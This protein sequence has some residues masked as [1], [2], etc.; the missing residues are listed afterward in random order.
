MDTVVLVIHLIFAIALIALVLIQR[1]E[2]GGLGIG[3]GSGGLGAFASAQST[4]NILTRLTAIFAALF[5]LT[6]IIL[7]ILANQKTGTQTIIDR[8]LTDSSPALVQDQPLEEE[9]PAD[10]PIPNVPIE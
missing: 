2:G 8:A 10:L 9:K 6:S 7:G 1:S 3:G 4:G 5:F